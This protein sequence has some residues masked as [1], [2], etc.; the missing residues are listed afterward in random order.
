M[1]QV[2]QD[3]VA[4]TDKWPNNQIVSQTAREYYVHNWCIFIWY[5]STVNLQFFV[6]GKWK[7]LN[8]FELHIRC[9]N[10]CGTLEISSVVCVGIGLVN[11]EQKWGLQF[12]TF[13]VLQK[14]SMF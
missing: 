7:R 9:N 8:I 10:G 5:V 6:I 4:F 3:C 1:Q 2:C 11:V 13:K 12:F 14:A